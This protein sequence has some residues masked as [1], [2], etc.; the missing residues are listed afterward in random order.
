M[1]N[2]TKPKEQKSNPLPFTE[3]EENGRTYYVHKKTKFKTTLINKMK[4]HC[5]KRGEEV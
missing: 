2:E 3:I 1:T 5:R 4:N